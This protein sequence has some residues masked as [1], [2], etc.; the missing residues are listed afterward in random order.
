MN[1]FKIKAK[2]INRLKEASGY[3]VSGF[4]HCYKNEQAFKMELYALGLLLLPGYVLADSF[5]EFAILISTLLFVLLIEVIN[6]A[7][8]AAVDR[9]GNEYNEFS[10]VAKDCGS[11]AVMISIIIAL[12]I[13]AAV[14]IK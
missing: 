9:M 13:W 2:G 7:I 10:K 1:D 12:L 4:Q 8:E 14:L 11:L 6:S 3:S 5:L